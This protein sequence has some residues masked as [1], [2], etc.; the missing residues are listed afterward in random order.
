VSSAEPYGVAFRTLG[1]KVNRAESESIAAELLGRGAR[2]V[3]EGDARVVIVSTCTVTREADA[4][5]RK[6]IRHALA[7]AGRPTVVVT[8]CGAVVDPEVL[9]ALSDRVIVEPDKS[10]VAARIAEI[11]A[12]PPTEAT[13]AGAAVHQGKAFR[14]RALLKV[15]DGCDA[16][17]TY[18][19]VPYARGVPEAVPLKQLRREAASLVAAGAREI[20]LTG[21]N[22]GRYSDGEARLPRVIEVVS[23]SGVDRLR[24]SSIEPLD[25]TAELLELLSATPAFCPHLHVP[26][27]SGS[28]AVLSAMGRRYTAAEFAERIAASRGALPGL[29]VTTDVLTGFPGE[30]DSD[31]EDTANLCQALGLSSLHVFRY[32]PREGTPAAA[33]SSPVAPRVAAVRAARLRTLGETLRQAHVARRLGSDACVLIETNDAQGTGRGTT[34]DY[35]RVS[36]PGAGSRRGQTV[37]VRLQLGADGALLGEPQA[38]AC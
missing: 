38:G 30:T 35:L 1:C 20:V 36:V 25:L 19:I 22:I 26:L 21:I 5:D 37:R 15:Q 34:E 2:T 9:S 17:C 12:L 28:D 8:G 23:E 32:S 31:A 24:L 10:R 27:Q 3:D 13:E 11:L 29:S 6:A 14:T 16:F 33:M 18:C 4:K 7:A